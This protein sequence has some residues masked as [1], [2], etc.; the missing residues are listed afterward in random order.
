MKTRTV[1][2]ISLDVWGC[3]APR[4]LICST[5]FL[6]TTLSMLF[7]FVF[8]DTPPFSSTVVYNTIQYNTA[9]YIRIKTGKRCAVIGKRSFFLGG[10]GGE[11]QS[12]SLGRSF[13]GIMNEKSECPTSATLLIIIPRVRLPCALPDI[14]NNLVYLNIF[15]VDTLDDVT[16]WESIRKRSGSRTPDPRPS[17]A[18]R[19][20]SPLP[21]PRFYLLVQYEYIFLPRCEQLV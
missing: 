6:A 10:G 4:V 1:W 21:Q 14:Q 18:F 3:T 15:F 8:L 16:S 11:K 12:R 17:I 13:R 20:F 5:A 2:G 9:A 19:F 7:F